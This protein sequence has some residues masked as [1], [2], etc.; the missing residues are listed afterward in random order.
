MR[1]AFVESLRKHGAELRRNAP[2]TR[3]EA[4]GSR[5]FVRAAD[6]EHEARCVVSNVDVKLTTEM[7]A[8]ARPGLLARRKIRRVRPSLGTLSVYV[9]TDMDVR[10]HGL[11]DFNVWHYGTPDIDGYYQRVYDGEIPEDPFFILT[12]PSLKDPD[13][14]PVPNGHT[15]LEVISLAPAAPFLRWFDDRPRKRGLDYE[16]QKE[17]LTERLLTAAERYL[18]GLS[19]HVVLRDSATPATVWHFVRGV[20]G[21]IYGPE[22]SPDQAVFR[23]FLPTIGVPGLYLAGAST[24]G[25]GVMTCLL[26][27]I[28]AAAYARAWL[29]R[30]PLRALEIP[31]RILA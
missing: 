3:I 15:T 10:A 17:V 23:R 12:S 14:P 13:G 28:L 25:P 19:R 27:G 6:E 21:G 29:R 22:L 7:L 30:G 4:R 20:M 26:S 2:V 5:F 24:L 11:R 9:A 31:T 8:G 18:P 1:D 16:A